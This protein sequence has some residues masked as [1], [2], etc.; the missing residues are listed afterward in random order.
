[1]VIVYTRA[2][3]QKK[4]GIGL[5]LFEIFIYF[6]YFNGLQKGT[7][8]DMLGITHDTGW[9]Y[10]KYASILAVFFFVG[11]PNPNKIIKP[12]LILPNHFV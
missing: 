5:E 4:S 10:T 2:T 1:M 3:E 6:I 8:T 11:L 7:L 9:T 12:N